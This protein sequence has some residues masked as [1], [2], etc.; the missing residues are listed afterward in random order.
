MENGTKINFSAVF[1]KLLQSLNER[2]Q[3]VLRRRYQ[4]TSDLDDYQTLQ[5]IGN[6]Y[7]IT[8]ERVRQIE[9]EGVRKLKEAARAVA[10]AQDLQGVV[11][12]LHRFLERHGGLAN[13][14]YLMENF[15]LPSHDLE[16]YHS[17]AYLFAIDQLVDSVEK[18]SDSE[19]FPDFWKLSNFNHG[20]VEDV[21]NKVVAELE[22][23]KIPFDRETLMQAI[24]KNVGAEHKEHF[25]QLIS[26]HT[27]LNE[28]AFLNTYVDFSKSIKGNI[29]GEYGM[30]HWDNILPK[31]LGDKIYLVLKRTGQPL[32]FN[33]IAE[34]VNGS[35]F[36]GKKVC[37]ATIHNE[38]IFNDKFILANRGYYA[39]K[40]WNLI[41]GTVGDLIARVLRDAGKPMTLKEI[42]AK[43]LE[44]RPVNQTTIYLTLLNNKRGLFNR[45]DKGVFGLN[46]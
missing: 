35:D 46:Q 31:R 15:I 42:C 16:P 23:S 26:K 9:N 40:E 43:V 19:H 27:D 29:L 20:L 22:A 44:L 25:G 37:P 2:E 18:V 11:L 28:D 36:P 30:S 6:M 33:E 5:E 1:A 24:K 3:E 32:H 38:L 12:H 45:V 14:E 10:F 7:K 39:L 34:Q 21:F 41:G 8:R 13:E 4:L 17:Q